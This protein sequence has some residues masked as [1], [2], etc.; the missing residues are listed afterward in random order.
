MNERTKCKV[1]QNLLPSY[2][3]NLLSDETKEYVENHLE[4]CQECKNILESMKE[5][6]KINHEKSEKANVNYLKKFKNKMSILKSILLVIIIIFLFIIGRRIVIV[7]K[8]SDNAKNIRANT[9]NNYYAKVE[10]IFAGAYSISECYYKDGN[11]MIKKTSY[12]KDEGEEKIIFYKNG[13]E[14]LLL[15]DS[16]YGKFMNEDVILT[17][18]SVLPSYEANEALNMALAYGVEA[19]T[20]GEKEC[21][22]LKD[23][24]SEQYIDKDTG[25]LVKQINRQNDTITDYEYEFGIVKDEDL[26]LPDISEYTSVNN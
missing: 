2:I 10:G 14:C 1:I 23:K 19:V 8:L 7:T 21:Y 6:M 24:G 26:Q 5:S 3:D 20:L 16:K 15:T 13:T 17:E 9:G 11:Y 22:V 25:L 12:S 18:I 4:E